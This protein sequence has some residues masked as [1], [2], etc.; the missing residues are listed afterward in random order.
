MNFFKKFNTQ[1]KLK[2]L[3]PLDIPIFSFDGV[4]KFAR[5]HKVYDGDTCTLLFR[6]KKQNI[7]ISCR[8]LGIDTPEI[9]TRNA[10]EK[11]AGYKARDFL[12]GLI[13]EKI[14]M[15]HFSKFDKY[16]RPLIEIFLNNG[17]PISNIMISNGY[18]RSYNGG[19]KIPFK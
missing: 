7:K 6:W 5:I 8:I 12:I 1:R 13:Y 15:V 9:R 14:L 16:G 10:E 11:K 4:K 3:E 2:K 19:T 17:Q 18:A